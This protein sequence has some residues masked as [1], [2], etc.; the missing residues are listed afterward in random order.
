MTTSAIVRS[1]APNH[2]DLMVQTQMVDSTGAWV[3]AG[4]PTRLR[5]GGVLSEHVY[6]GKRLVITEAARE[7]PRVTGLGAAA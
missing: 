5:E 6:G 4:P 7:A 2:Q 1:P 3:D